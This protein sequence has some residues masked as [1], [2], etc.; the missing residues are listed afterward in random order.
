MRYSKLFI[1]SYEESLQLF[2]IVPG[3][4]DSVSEH[5]DLYVLIGCFESLQLAYLVYA[6]PPQH[7]D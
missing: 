7:A 4:E 2:Y 5:V 1:I 6:Q 3:G